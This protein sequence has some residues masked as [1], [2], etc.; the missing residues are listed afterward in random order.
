MNSIKVTNKTLQLDGRTYQ[1]HHIIYIE[2]KHGLLKRPFTGKALGNAFVV[3]IIAI[4]CT[5]SD[6]IRGLASIVAFLAAAILI[7][8]IYRNTRPRDV[9][10]LEMLIS[11]Q[12]HRFI[13]SRNESAI[14]DLYGKICMAFES[15]SPYANTI[16]ISGS[17]FIN[18]SDLKDVKITSSSGK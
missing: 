14:D 4:M 9:W 15:D 13:G 3:L 16:N 12:S 10:F 5:A 11:E 18:E 7:L 2:K 1:K 8:L 17:T 6:A